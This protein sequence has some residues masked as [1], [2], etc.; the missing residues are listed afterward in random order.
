MTR[1]EQVLLLSMLDSFLD[2]GLI[3]EVL[4]F[5][6]GGKEAT[7]FRCRAGRSSRDGARNGAGERFFAAKVYR[8]QKY[9][10]FRDDA[11]YQDGRVI[12]DARA[13]RAAKKNSAFGQQVH[14]GLWVAA[15]Y[16]TQQMLHEAG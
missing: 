15:E 5:V 1:D 4:E 12:L 7:V 2:S 11:N 16:E 3:S 8:P 10:R 9:R 14:Q 13:R 6:K